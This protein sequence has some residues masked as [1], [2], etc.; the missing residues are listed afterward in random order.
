MNNFITQTTR[1]LNRPALVYLVYW[2]LNRWV[3]V[4]TIWLISSQCYWVAAVAV[5][6]KKYWG[7]VG[8]GCYCTHLISTLFLVLFASA[9][10][11]L[12]LFID[13]V[14]TVCV[15]WENRKLLHAPK[16]A[17]LRYL[18]FC[19]CICVCKNSFLGGFIVNFAHVWLNFFTPSS[20]YMYVLLQQSKHTFMISFTPTRCLH[21]EFY[22][23]LDYWQLATM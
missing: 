8:I 9:C 11:K 14:H 6:V 2:S 16:L 12:Q 15:H 22:L 3:D 7:K 18:K 23:A 20:T 5:L 13:C 1:L 17:D 4:V 19:L 10:C 21:S